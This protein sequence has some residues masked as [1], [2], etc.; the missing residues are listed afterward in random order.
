MQSCEPAILKGTLC[1]LRSKSSMGT[2]AGQDPGCMG[3]ET[4]VGLQTQN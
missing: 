1:V 2:H 4:Y 3:Y